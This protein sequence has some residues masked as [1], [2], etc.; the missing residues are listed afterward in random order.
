[1]VLRIHSK[2]INHP[3]Q[4]APSHQNPSSKHQYHL[5][6]L[7]NWK[8]LPPPIPKMHFELELFSSESPNRPPEQW[9]G[10]QREQSALIGGR[11][12]PLRPPRG[13]V[14]SSASNCPHHPLLIKQCVFLPQ[15]I[16]SG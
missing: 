14:V 8:H 10:E 3:L 9:P 11:R 5:T 1:M 7:S 16:P 15:L 4:S 6:L 12:P 13:P 2:A